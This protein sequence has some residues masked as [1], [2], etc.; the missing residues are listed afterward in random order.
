MSAEFENTPVPTSSHKDWK[1]FLG[2][3]AG[4]HA[5]GT[6]FMIGPLFLAAGASLKDLL[7]G[8]LVGNILALLTII[9][10]CVI[11]NRKSYLRTC[12]RYQRIDVYKG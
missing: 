12:A 4:E 8:L 2:M 11:G 1:T 7:F 3:F 5:A 10:L 6:E 9:F